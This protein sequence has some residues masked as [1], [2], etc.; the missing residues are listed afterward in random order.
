MTLYKIPSQFLPR[1]RTETIFSKWFGSETQIGIVDG[2]S[3]D[4]SRI[5]ARGRLLPS[6]N[7]SRAYLR[8]SDDLVLYRDEGYETLI[9]QVNDTTAGNHNPSYTDTGWA[10]IISAGAMSPLRWV[11]F[12]YELLRPNEPNGEIQFKAWAQSQTHSADMFYT[13]IVSGRIAMGP[14]VGMQFLIT[15]GP[16]RGFIEVVGERTVDVFPPADL[17]YRVAL[18][19]ASLTSYQAGWDF[20]L[21]DQLQAALPDRHVVVRN[22]ARGST[23]SSAGLLNIG[24]V[25]ACEPDAVIIEYAQADSVEGVPGI[26]M[27]QAQSEENTQELCDIL[28]ARGIVPYLMTGSPMQT[29]GSSVRPNQLAYNQIYRDVAG[30]FGTTGIGLIDTYPIFGSPE[31]MEFQND[32]GIHPTPAENIAVKVP[33]AVAVLT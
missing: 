4:W 13:N 23:D 9:N 2:I 17:P 27:S 7:D 20:E 29:P 30:S 33:A 10:G 26:G 24:S 32:D 28:K 1:P 14:V 8:L 18:M 21:Q 6:V 12:E 31:D 5:I 22:F 3:G 15:D 25:I 16:A 11:D 19:G